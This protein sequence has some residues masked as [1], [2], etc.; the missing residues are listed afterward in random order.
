[1]NE[2][3]DHHY[4]PQFYL[5]NFAVDDQKKKIT[6]VAKNG[7]FSVWNIRSIESLGYERDL[8]VNMNKGMPISVE[9]DINRRVETPISKSET[10]AKIASGRSDHLDK[11]DMPILY[12]LIRH[13]EA[14]TPHYRATTKEL[15]RLAISSSKDI[16]FTEEER[17]HYAFLHANPELGKMTF[18]LMASSLAWTEESFSRACISILRS[19]IPLRSSSTPAVSMSVPAHPSLY[20]PLPG[21]V[22]YQLLLPLNRTT[23]A[24]LIL[25]DFDDNFTNIEINEDVARAFN[26]HFVGQFAHFENIRHLITDRNDLITDMTWAPFDL[27]KD[28][29]QKITFRRRSSENN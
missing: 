8:Y 26:R 29:K 15:A 24:S 16:P 3:R 17:K 21:M 28:T 23:M 18:N 7:E 1:M 9:I 10:W 12:A 13:F 5:R 4:V 22:P 19:P 6:T 27:I 11:S 14:R 20:L 25:A 2:P